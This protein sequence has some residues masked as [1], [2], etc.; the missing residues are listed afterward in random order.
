LDLSQ[1]LFTGNDFVIFDF[2]GDPDR[3]VSQRRTKTSPLCDV[4]S[5]I[6][7]FQYASR[8]VTIG[9]ERACLLPTES[10]QHTASWLGVWFLWIAAAYLKAYL[11]KAAPGGFLPS[12]RLDRETLLTAYLLDK[13]VAEIE[14]ELAGRPDWLHVPLEGAL[15]VLDRSKQPVEQPQPD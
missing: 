10:D 11:E 6:R 14:R 5:M 2:E 3:P 7:S 1:V 15:Q 4:A 8:V 12:S 9:P 13:A